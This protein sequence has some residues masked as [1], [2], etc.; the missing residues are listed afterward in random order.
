MRYMAVATDYD[1]TLARDGQVAPATLAALEALKASG[2]KTI[3]TTGRHLDD[4]RRV[5]PKID[6]FDRIVAENGAV[7]YD[8]ASR[9]ETLLAEEPPAELLNALRRAGVKFDV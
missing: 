8:P 5:F 1:G 7:L 4:L 9:E 3:L 2:R 6:L